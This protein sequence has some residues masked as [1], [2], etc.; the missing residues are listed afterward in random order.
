MWWLQRICIGDNGVVWLIFL[1]ECMNFR[2]H[3]TLLRVP[4]WV[5]LRSCQLV[6]RYSAD[7]DFASRLYSV[8][9]RIKIL[10]SSRCFSIIGN[11]NECIGLFK[12]SLRSIRYSQT[13]VSVTLH[14]L[15]L[16]HSSRLN[17]YKRGMSYRPEDWSNSINGECRLDLSVRRST[18]RKI[19]RYQILVAQKLQSHA[20]ITF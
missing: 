14:L 9:P 4:N 16:L 17:A 12:L 6:V 7:D 19:V 5:L 13:S 2:I 8:I 1:Y 18:H 3:V 20:E 11:F 10:L 15:R